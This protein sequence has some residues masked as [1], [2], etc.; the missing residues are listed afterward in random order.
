M[1]PAASRL[2]R[3][4]HWGA[5][6]VTGAV[7]V[8]LIA[9]IVVIVPLSF[10]SGTLL[11]YPVP[12]WS[13]RWYEDFVTS[14]MWTRATWNSFF[15]AGVTTV[16]ATALGVS[17]ALGLHWSH[18]HGKRIL[19]A[20]LVTPLVVPV[21]IVAVA[22]FYYF[23]WLNL[24]GTY[25]G[26]IVA[27]TVLAVP[28]VLITVTATLRGFDVNLARAAASLGARPLV[29]FRHVVLPV[30]MPGVVS[31]ALFAFVTSFDEIVVALFIASPAQRT[32]PR[33]IF[34]GVSESISPTILAAAVVLV[35]VS[36]SLMAVVEILR[37][38][39]E[40][41]RGVGPSTR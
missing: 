11:V 20:I 28:F 29:A 7:M 38:R 10:T 15:I 3:V 26:M 33:Q 31:G 30:I 1:K 24:V 18:F 25:V 34:S 9:P 12:G 6:L 39:G 17:A 14:P 37:R 22:M 19:V 2:E 40:R 27:H 5:R 4:A 13:L 41:L 32:L 8:Y 36:A 21:V 23:A 16:L 35:I